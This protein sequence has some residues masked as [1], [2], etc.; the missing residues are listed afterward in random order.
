MTED[1]RPREVW[2][3]VPVPGL[4]VLDRLAQLS[5][6]RGASWRQL[7]KGDTLRSGDVRIHVW[8]P[9]PVRIGSGRG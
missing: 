2:E 1:F 9:R 5:A 6:D 8:H 3:G 7:Q 4:A